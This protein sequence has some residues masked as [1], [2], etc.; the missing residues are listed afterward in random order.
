MDRTGFKTVYKDRNVECLELETYEDFDPVARDSASFRLM[1][2]REGFRI[3]TGYKDTL[4]DLH[5][6]PDDALFSSWNDACREVYDRYSTQECF[7][8]FADYEDIAALT[9]L[10]PYDLVC[11]IQQPMRWVLAQPVHFFIWFRNVIVNAFHRPT[12]FDD[13]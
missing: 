5:W 4:G 11:S 6:M 13:C 10:L 8:K 12:D 2:T 3:W 9:F 7:L 1:R